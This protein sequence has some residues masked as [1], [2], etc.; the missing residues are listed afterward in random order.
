LT[1]EG[2][3]SRNHGLCETAGLDARMYLARIV[4]NHVELSTFVI[5][6]M[7]N[8]NIT[9][10]LQQLTKVS[11][12]GRL[13]LNSRKI[14][15]NGDRHAQRAHTHEGLLLSRRCCVHCILREFGMGIG[16]RCVCTRCE[17]RVHG[18]AVSGC[19]K[20]GLLRLLSSLH[21][22]SH[23]PLALWKSLSLLWV[24]WDFV[25]AWQTCRMSAV[26]RN[27]S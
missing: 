17:L 13:A 10:T 5:N 27:C 2:D 16:V 1:T 24:R 11:R 3:R 25:N 4:I 9:Q 7:N 12:H 8:F 21:R 22:V 6:E 26:A 19:P 20:L 18:V 14:R 23:V 15:Q